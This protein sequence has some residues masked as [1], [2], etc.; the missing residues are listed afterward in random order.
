[1][2][3]FAKIIDAV[4]T[5]RTD[6][7]YGGILT[8]QIPTRFSEL[9]ANF[10]SNTKYIELEE[11]FPGRVKRDDVLVDIGCGKGRVINHWLSHFPGQKLYGIEL[12]PEIAI[13][14]RKRLSRFENVTIL[15]GDAIEQIPTD[16]TL[17]YVC[18]SF[19]EKPM[20]RFRDK[21]VSLFYSEEAKAWKR[22]IRIF[23]FNPVHEDIYRNDPRFEI[24]EIKMTTTQLRVIMITAK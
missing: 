15:D 19:T 13:P 21:I 16:G 14:T 5:I 4:R 7:K 11:I 3:L 6:L 17:F 2:A 20:L 22:P 23:Y 1:M 8:G 12:D 18:N 10:T 24:E 9:G